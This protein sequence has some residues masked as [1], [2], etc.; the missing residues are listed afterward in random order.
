MAG[1]RSQSMPNMSP[2]QVKVD[3]LTVDHDL[4]DAVLLQGVMR[5]VTLGLS[6][7]LLACDSTP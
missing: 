6:H 4:A 3:A 5:N 2:L 7:A 1:A